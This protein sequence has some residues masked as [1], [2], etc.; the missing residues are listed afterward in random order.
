MYLKF[1]KGAAVTIMFLVVSRSR[2]L[3]FGYIHA[4]K[5]DWS[6]VRKWVFSNWGLLQ[7]NKAVGAYSA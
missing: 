6:K 4:D 1:E 3:R 5:C 7:W 2:Y